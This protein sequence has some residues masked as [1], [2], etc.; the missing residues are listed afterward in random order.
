MNSLL[1]ATPSHVLGSLRGLLQGRSGCSL[2]G[3]LQGRSGSSLEH[4]RAPSRPGSVPGLC[5]LGGMSDPTKTRGEADSDVQLRR[6]TRGDLEAIVALL[7][8]DPLGAEREDSRSPLP[9]SYVDAFAEIDGDAKQRL[10][11]AAADD[12]VL[13]VLQLTFIPYLTYRGRRRAL[14]EGVRIAK[15]ARGRGLGRRLMQWAIE[16]ARRE[17]CHLIQLTTDKRRPAAIEFY[18]GLGF[19]DSHEGMKLHFGA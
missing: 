7:A 5:Y 13:G 10:M 14:V 8:D 11:V 6:A 3:L 4:C 16:A 17:G 12:T 1:T 2:R 18:R 19:I 15:I 9:Q